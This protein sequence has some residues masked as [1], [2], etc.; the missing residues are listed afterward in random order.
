MRTVNEIALET[1]V[2]ELEKEIKVLKEFEH[3]VCMTCAKI[4]MASMF[5]GNS[6]EEMLKLAGSAFDSLFGLVKDRME[7]RV[8]QSL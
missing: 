7:E 8:K 3:S 2:Q 1:K 4:M 5:A 6:K